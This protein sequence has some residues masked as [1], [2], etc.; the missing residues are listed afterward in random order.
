MTAILNATGKPVD[1]AQVDAVIKA[2]NNRKVDEV[3]VILLRSSARVFLKYLSD[4]V[5][6]LLLRMRRKRTRRKRKRR[7]KRRRKRRKKKRRSL[8]P[9]LKKRKTSLSISLADS[10]KPLLEI[11][12]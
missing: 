6:L 9:S 3:S 11:F 12:F 4:L 1:E 8:N 5:L 7:K 10:F 2:L